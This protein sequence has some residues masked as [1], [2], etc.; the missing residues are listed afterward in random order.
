MKNHFENKKHQQTKIRVIAKYVKGIFGISNDPKG[1]SNKKVDQKT[2]VKDAL[3]NNKL[4]DT[5][6][7][8]SELNII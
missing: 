8:S 1:L 5:Y 2:F 3:N 7:Q 4:V 6:C